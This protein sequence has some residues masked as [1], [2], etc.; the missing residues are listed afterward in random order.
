MATT[1]FKNFEF[2]ADYYRVLGVEASAT[3][4]EIRRSYKRLALA[5]HPDKNP[6][7]REWAEARIRE[8]I[9]AY[10]VLSNKDTRQAFD[11]YLR[12]AGSGRS[13]EP[14]FFHRKTPTARALLILHYLLK[15]RA[16]EAA[17]ILEEMEEEY[18]GDYL[19]QYLERSD[20]LDCLF[21][22]AEHYVRQKNYLAAAERLRTF[23]HHDCQ[24]TNPRHYLDQVVDLLKDLYLRKLPGTLDPA[25]VVTYLTEAAQ[26][27]L[28][29][30]DEL[31]RLRLLAE[32]AARAGKATTAYAAIARIRE[33][34]GSSRDLDRLEGIL[35]HYPGAGVADRGRR[36]RRRAAKK[37]SRGIRRGA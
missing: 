19:Y 6:H 13:R 32:T 34:A 27:G 22:L 8:L 17:A 30:K 23:Y 24:A 15:D 20:Y 16:D 28:G 12:S 14:F 9:V 11:R 10:E 36:P 35:A 25:L 3:A 2:S 1:R 29:G 26:F 5:V 21:L 18:G 37:G 33:I 31:L 4:D 7:R